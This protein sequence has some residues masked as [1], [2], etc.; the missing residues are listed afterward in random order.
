M[1]LSHCFGGYGTM[2]IVAIR[3]ERNN[4]NL[5]YK[6]DLKENDYQI[7]DFLNKKNLKKTAMPGHKKEPYGIPITKKTDILDKL[8][9]VL[10]ENRKPFWKNLPLTINI[11]LSVSNHVKICDYNIIINLLMDLDTS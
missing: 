5:L 2:H 9:Q 3:A 8:K 4:F 10:P 6:T 7:L 1:I 11:S